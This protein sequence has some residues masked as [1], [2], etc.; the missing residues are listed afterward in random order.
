MSNS[1]E[2]D[3][4]DVELIWLRVAMATAAA[5]TTCVLVLACIGARVGRDHDLP[6]SVIL[7]GAAAVA[8]ALTVVL[9]RITRGVMIGAEGRWWVKTI[10][11]QFNR[12][13][14]RR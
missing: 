3:N 6:P 2:F 5:T 7:V 10:R 13:L 11:T 9:A 8:I 14:E 4:A 12:L 1:N